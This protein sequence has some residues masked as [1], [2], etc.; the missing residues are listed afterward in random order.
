MWT[1]AQENAR[2]SDTESGGMTHY[3]AVL[4]YHDK[5]AG[6]EVEITSNWMTESAAR[7]TLALLEDRF[8]KSTGGE[9]QSTREVN[10]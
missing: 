10:P 9:I 6:G 2:D 7:R 5:P 1:M 4:T 3:R 8:P